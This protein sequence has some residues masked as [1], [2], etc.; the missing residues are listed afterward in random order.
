MSRHRLL[1]AVILGTTIV[2]IGTGTAVVNLLQDRLVAGVDDQLTEFA[3]QRPLHTFASV[4]HDPAAGP[5]D[6]RHMAI[7]QLSPDGEIRAAIP[8]GPTTEPDPLPDVAGIRLGVQPRTVP[9]LDVGPTTGP[10][11]CC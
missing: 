4:N 6:D 8:S 2:L 5:F 1:A 11:A 9:A 10:S 3:S 7:L